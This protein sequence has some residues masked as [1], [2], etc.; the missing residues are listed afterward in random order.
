MLFLPQEVSGREPSACL[1]LPHPAVH[2]DPRQA[3][4][5][6]LRP[7]TSHRCRTTQN[8]PEH[9]STIHKTHLLTPDI[10][11]CACV[12]RQSTTHLLSPHP[13]PHSPS[14]SCCALPKITKSAP[15]HARLHPEDRIAPRPLPHVHAPTREHTRILPTLRPRPGPQRAQHSLPCLHTQH[16][17]AHNAHAQP[18]RLCTAQ[19]YLGL[20]QLSAIR[21]SPRPSF[22]PISCLHKTKIKSL[23]KVP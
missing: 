16:T 8:N 6:P 21:L 22:Y 23:F 12:H 7:S 14:A 13:F 4:S 1:L 9:P 17:P 5:P 18:Y 10:Y 3:D 15:L 19:F 20:Q 2:R 11:L